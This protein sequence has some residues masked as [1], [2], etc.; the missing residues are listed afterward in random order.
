[1]NTQQSSLADVKTAVASE[2]DQI[3]QYRAEMA[4]MAEESS[5]A[6]KLVQSSLVSLSKNMVEQLS[7]GHGAS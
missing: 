4:K 3:R 7:G 5:A 2:L 6:V 1:M